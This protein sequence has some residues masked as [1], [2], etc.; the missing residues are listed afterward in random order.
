MVGR[1]PQEFATQPARQNL[2]CGYSEVAAESAAG[3]QQTRRAAGPAS[4]EIETEPARLTM[5]E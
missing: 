5:G 3:A 1:D 2:A 4:R